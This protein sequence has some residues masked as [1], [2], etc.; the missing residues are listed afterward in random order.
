MKIS[1]KWINEFVDISGINPNDISEKLTIRT[2]ETEGITS[3]S[4]SYKSITAAYIEHA[5]RIDEN[6][7]KCTVLA[8]R[9]YTV[10]SGAPNTNSGIQCIYVKPGG[11]IDGNIIETK[12]IA[13]ISSEGMLLS[14]KELGINNDHSG[15]ITINE[16]FK[17][18]TDIEDICGFYDHIIEIDNKSLTHRPDLWGIYGIAREIAAIFGLHLKPYDIMSINALPDKP[19]PAISIKNTDLCYRYI[20]INIDN[21]TINESPLY[22][23][24]RLM[25]TEHVPRNLIVDLTNYV[26]TEIGQPLHAFDGSSIEHIIVDTVNEKTQYTTLD[27]I[28]RTL[29]N[30]TLMIMNNNENIAIAGIMGG[31]NSEISEKSRSMFLEAASFNAGHIRKTSANLNLRTD[32]SARF[33]K[34]LDPEFAYIGAMRYLKL[35]K[36]IQPDIHFASALRDINHNPFGRN[37]IEISY[38]KIFEVIGKD[39]GKK[40]VNNILKSL[41]FDVDNS[42]TTAVVTAPTFRSTKDISIE[43]DIIEEISRMYGFENIESELPKQNISVP[44]VNYMQKTENL[45]RHFLS[46]EMEMN[47]TDSYI[48]FDNKFNK[49]IDFSINKHT[50]KLKN[51]V[52]QEHTYLRT[53]MI[54]IMLEHVHE[55]LKYFDSFSLYEMGSVFTDKEEHNVLSIIMVQPKRK[56]GNEQLFLKMK[57]TLNTLIER[58]HYSDLLLTKQDAPMLNPVN[59]SSIHIN[60]SKCGYMGSVHPSFNRV[61]DKKVDIVFLEIDLNSII[62]RP[63]HTVFKPYSPFPISNLDFSIMK[64]SDETFISFIGTIN[65]FKSNLIIHS[66]MIDIYENNDIKGF[67]SVTYRFYLGLNERTLNNDDIVDFQSSFIQYINSK[68]YKLR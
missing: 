64:P 61:L 43:A 9:K 60:S 27:N 58:L 41:E 36:D 15:L 56:K 10:I 57:Y 30:E 44:H 3:I 2:A 59:A 35:L 37:K 24:A 26:M 47:E 29:N 25:R 46:Y 18:D 63:Q 67:Q 49:M 32:S 23:Q 12:N 65:A 52:S 53:T 54:P 31:G 28:N 40:R 8:D 20:G 68:G 39:I 34:S 55:N 1:L 50:V 21:I 13:G 22:M 4:D 48:W 11:M 51:P 17:P 14:G 45:I 33:E 62:L 38:S 42:D 6:H 66:E 19:L 5:E 16:R 7:F